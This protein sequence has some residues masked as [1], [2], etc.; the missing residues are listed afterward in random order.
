MREARFIAQAMG[1]FFILAGDLLPPPNGAA[2][3]SL[4]QPR[5]SAQKADRQTQRVCRLLKHEVWL[6]DDRWRQPVLDMIDNCM[7]RA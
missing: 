6:Y 7:N 5:Q 3:D 4:N 2:P 1:R